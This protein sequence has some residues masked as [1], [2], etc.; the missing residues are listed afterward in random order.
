MQPSLAAI[1]RVGLNSPPAR[2]WQTPPDDRRIQLKRQ[3]FRLSWLIS[4]NA[5]IS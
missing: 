5:G 4:S 2:G 3:D 1:G